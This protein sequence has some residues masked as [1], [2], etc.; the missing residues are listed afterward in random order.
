MFWFTLS[1]I[2]RPIKGYATTTL[3]ITTLAYILCALVTTF[4]WRHK[5]MDVQLPITLNCPVSLDQI[6]DRNGRSAAEHYHFTPLDFV[7]RQEWIGSKL[8]VYY[9]NLLRKMRIIHVY[10]KP[11]PIRNFS[12]FNFMLPDRPFLFIIVFLSTAYSSIFV[13]AWSLHFPTYTERLLWRISSTGTMVITL[14]GGTFEVVGMLLQYRRRRPFVPDSDSEHQMH[15]IPTPIRSQP[16]VFKPV[17]KLEVIMQNA[18][19]KTPDKDPHY[20]IPIRSLV[21]T[22]PL[23]ALYCW[24]RLILLI[25][26]IITF[27]KLPA[28]AFMAIDWSMYVPHI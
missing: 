5:P 2:S 19:N 12:S 4:F 10:P 1:T 22:T 11:L 9:T 3:E 18:R 7:S 21:F 14:L 17:T 6:V 23:C 25:E 15:V 26:D 24:F 27:R 28:S 16:L 13:A 8:W 20:D